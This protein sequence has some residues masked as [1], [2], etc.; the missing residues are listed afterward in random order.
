M[1]PFFHWCSSGKPWHRTKLISGGPWT[2]GGPQL[3]CYGKFPS[4]RAKCCWLQQL[5][6]QGHILLSFNTSS[7]RVWVSLFNIPHPPAFK[8]LAFSCLLLVGKP[9]LQ[10]A[11]LGC[12]AL[13]N[14]QDLGNQQIASFI[15][16]FI[17]FFLL[18]SHVQS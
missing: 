17:Y 13:K 4:Q 8:P 1:A 10:Q 5:A 3:V 18:F 9:A 15:I 7:L 6:L 11:P 14:S 16:L 2:A 12:K